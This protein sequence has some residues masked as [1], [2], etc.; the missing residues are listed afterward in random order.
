MI[1]KINLGNIQAAATQAERA[2]ESESGR[3]PI[4][5]YS[6]SEVADWMGSVAAGLE[7]AHPVAQK[8]AKGWVARNM[9]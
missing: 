8:M 9:Q 2:V 1:Y 7:D 3:D 5:G 4:S 6:Y